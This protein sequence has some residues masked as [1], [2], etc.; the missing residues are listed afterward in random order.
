[1]TITWWGKGFFKELQN[2]A[3][4]FLRFQ[5]KTVKEGNEPSFKY[6]ATCFPSA[7]FES[8]SCPWK[9]LDKK[10][11]YIDIFISMARIGWH[12]ICIYVTNCQNHP[13]NPRFMLSKLFALWKE[14]YA[15]GSCNLLFCKTKNYILV[16]AS[17]F[18]RFVCFFVEITMR[19]QC[20]CDLF[21]LFG[22]FTFEN[23]FFIEIMIC[24]WHFGGFAFQTNLPPPSAALRTFSRPTIIWSDP[25]RS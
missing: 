8:G 12:I 14:K 6:P 5:G 4:L 10:L 23:K 19:T 20:G 17:F 16:N 3:C 21:L 24:M 18:I 9:Y 25:I 2:T 7:I 22:W 15:L 13:R 1:M 11:A